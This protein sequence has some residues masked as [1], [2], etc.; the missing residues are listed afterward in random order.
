M[1]EMSPEF[2]VAHLGKLLAVCTWKS[3]GQIVADNPVLLTPALEEMLALG[4]GFPGTPNGIKDHLEEVHRFIIRCRTVGIDDTILEYDEEKLIPT[5]LNAKYKFAIQSTEADPWRACI[6]DQTFSRAPRWFQ[7]SL[8]LNT[9]FSL[10][11][12]ESA[13]K[14]PSLLK[15]AE[16]LLNRGLEGCEDDPTKGMLLST[17]GRCLDRQAD[18]GDPS[19]RARAVTIHEEALRLTPIHSPRKALHTQAYALSIHN[20]A[21]RSEEL[22]DLTKAV[23]A[24]HQVISLAAPFTSN[25]MHISVNTNLA[26]LLVKMCF[27]NKDESHL[28]DAEA[29]V[30][31]ALALSTIRSASLLALA[32]NIAWRKLEYFGYE[33]ALNSAQALLE[34]ALKAADH[35]DAELRLRCLWSLGDVYQSL[36]VRGSSEEIRARWLQTAEM[37]LSIAAGP[38]ERANSMGNFARCLLHRYRNSHRQEDIDRAIASARDASALAQNRALL[39]TLYATLGHCLHDRYNRIGDELD[40]TEAESASTKAVCLSDDGQIERAKYLNDLGVVLRERYDL[41]RDIKLLERAISCHK[42]SIERFTPDRYNLSLFHHNLGFCLRQLYEHDDE[43]VAALERSIS[44]LELAVSNCPIDSDNRPLFLASL[45]SSLIER[46][47]RNYRPVDV[48]R[49]IDLRQEAFDSVPPESL[50]RIALAHQLAGAFVLRYAEA[51]HSESDLSRATALYEESCTRGLML[52]TEEALVSALNW[53]AFA[54]SRGAWDEVEKAYHV[55]EDATRLLM[56]RQVRRRAKQGWLINSHAVAAQAAY[57]FAKMGKKRDCALALERSRARIFTEALSRNHQD[58]TKLKL[59]RPALYEEYV[60]SDLECDR[61]LAETEAANEHRLEVLRLARQRLDKVVEKIRVLPDYNTFLSPTTFADVIA[62]AADT[63]LVYLSSTGVGG[64]AVIVRKNPIDDI[65]IVW[66]PQLTE[67][68]FRLKVSVSS[69]MHDYFASYEQC[70]ELPEDS[71]AFASWRIAIDSVCSWL[72]GAV[73]G[74]VLEEIDGAPEL[75]IIPTGLLSMLP[76]HAAWA[77]DPVKG[78]IYADSRV[79]IGYATNARSLR[80]TSP[81]ARCNEPSDTLIVVSDPRPTSLPPLKA[82]ESEAEIASLA[83]N[84]VVRFDGERAT[85]FNVIAAL[86]DSAVAHFACHGKAY[87]E[88]PLKSGLL[89]ANDECLS[90]QDCLTLNLTRSRL[91]ILSACETGLIGW[92]LPNEVVGLPS[93]LSEAGFLGVVASLWEVDDLATALLMTAFY[94]AWRIKRLNSSAALLDAQ[95]WVRDTSDREKLEFLTGS[96][97]AHKVGDYYTEVMG[98]IGADAGKDSFSFSHP[99]YWAGFIYIGHPLGAGTDHHV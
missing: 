78:R 9:S 40:L 99:Y 31:E 85:R 66:L 2:V 34:E 10:L 81:R 71:E 67:E 79:R 33:D 42:E 26:S 28:K 36:I 51:E 38:N 64:M 56:S 73:V 37:A 48:Q 24:W 50:D 92:Q 84:K 23:H 19:L 52:H 11:R 20:L 54:F 77:A 70:K 4:A 75:T 18:E 59:Q 72:W 53:A 82:A 16:E 32:G 89:L 94:H 62:A 93:A 39:A 21:S 87:P 57:S 5:E 49:V 13:K 8:L 68:I 63:P 95:R 96:S 17:L 14:Q 76:F 86:N 61:V 65:S 80:L 25:D 91:A 46:C 1:S 22:G 27:V 44:E 41:T 60:Q 30:N 55:F 3:L 74:P 98:L 69:E 58:L 45:G 88:T 6:R 15:E 29:L 43:D 97:G 12:Q 35:Q 83:F 90:V 47:R 7:R